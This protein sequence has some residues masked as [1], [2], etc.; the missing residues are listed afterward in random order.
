MMMMMMISVIDSVDRRS[1][2]DHIVDHVDVRDFTYIH[3]AGQMNDV[4]RLMTVMM[5]VL[6]VVVTVVDDDR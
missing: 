1:F 5:T 3:V 6:T 4:G 2:V